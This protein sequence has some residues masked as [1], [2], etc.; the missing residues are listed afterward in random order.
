MAKTKIAP[1]QFGESIAATHPSS[2]AL[3]LLARRRSTVAKNLADPG[4]TQDELETLLRIASRVPDHGKLSPW[5]FI[6]F[7]GEARKSFGDVLARAFQRDEP[8][9]GSARVDIERNR[10]MRAPVVT[11][12]ISHRHEDHKI[13]VW[14]QELSAGA[15]CQNILIASSAM[16]YAAQWLT[17]W[18]AYHPDIDEALQLQSNERVAGF[19]YIGTATCDPMERK[20]PDPSSLVSHWESA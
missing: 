17:E 1:P 4:P 15:V 19:I 13:P 9:A 16:G 5:R 2:D 20:R 6:V 12:V 7:R 11:A 8:D 3:S 10:F 18:Y 14:E